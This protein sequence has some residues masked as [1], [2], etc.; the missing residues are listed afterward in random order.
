MAWVPS[1]SPILTKKGRPV[2]VI[3][4][5]L[6]FGCLAFVNLAKSGGD[7]FNWLLALSGLSILFIYGSIALA[8]IR[9]RKAWALA[10]H[11]VDELPFKASCGVWGSY[12]CLLINVLGL[13][14]QFYVAL[15]PVGGP[16]LD[17]TT[18]FQAYL[19]GP[20]LI[21]LYLIWKVYSWFKR[22]SDRPLWVHI[23]DI[24]IYTGMRDTQQVISGAD[25]PE[26][27]RRASIAEMQGE[28]KKRGPKEYVMG[29]VRS[30]F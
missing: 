27:Q 10:G 17:P 30:V 18:F 6:L 2:S 19:A 28:K 22:P 13:I 5:Q 7:I 14:A 21:A 15:Y 12:L 26:E 11:T 29:V 16:N 25:V 1:Y 3:V 23:R 8:H 9:F 4:L 20:F 24:D